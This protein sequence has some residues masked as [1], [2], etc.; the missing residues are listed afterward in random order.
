MMKFTLCFV[1]LVVFAMESGAAPQMDAREQDTKPA[2]MDSS[3]TLMVGCDHPPAVVVTKDGE[4]VM[5]PKHPRQML[6]A[7]ESP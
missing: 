3:D 5:F 1:L 4:P 2:Q 6:S 7:E